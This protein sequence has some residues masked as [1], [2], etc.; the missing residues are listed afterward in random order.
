MWAN[1]HVWRSNTEVDN[2][3]CT[4]YLGVG[5]IELKWALHTGCTI[6]VQLR[7]CYNWDLER[8]F[9]LAR[10]VPQTNQYCTMRVFKVS[11]SRGQR[12]TLIGIESLHYMP[13]RVSRAKYCAK[14]RD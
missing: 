7:T 4:R 11:C 13:P 14:P 6:L 1:D 8:L 10:S 9:N 3:N 5:R 2:C 12:E